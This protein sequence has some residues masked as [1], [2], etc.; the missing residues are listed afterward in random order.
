[1]K[2]QQKEKLSENQQKLLILA[3]LLKDVDQ[4]LKPK[5][6]VSLLK[7][8]SNL[9]ETVLTKHNVTITDEI[10]IEIEDAFEKEMLK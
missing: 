10:K 4:A 5:R 2:K 3:N 1:M 9:V 6:P 7:K 8:V